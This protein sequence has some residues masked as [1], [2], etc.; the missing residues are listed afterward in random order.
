MAGLRHSTP[1]P[2]PEPVL[3]SRKH[4]WEIKP[5]LMAPADNDRKL[6][7][8]AEGGRST[9]PADGAG[10][11]AGAGASACE[12]QSGDASPSGAGAAGAA[13]SGGAAAAD[14]DM[15]MPPARLTATAELRVP[16]DM[17]ERSLLA[18]SAAA[19][20]AAAAGGAAPASAGG[21]AAVSKA[22]AAASPSLSHGLAFELPLRA[23]AGPP[24]A[25]AWP[26]G[27]GDAPPPAPEGAVV[28]AVSG[29]VCLLPLFKQDWWSGTAN[30]ALG[31]ACGVQLPV[32]ADADAGA[33]DAARGG[34]ESSNGGAGA[35]AAPQVGV[36][37]AAGKNEGAVGTAFGKG[38]SAEDRWAGGAAVDGQAAGRAAGRAAGKAA[39][40]AAGSVPLALPRPPRSAMKAGW[41]EE[42][43]ALRA[44]AAGAGAGAGVGAGAAAAAAAAATA[45][46]AAAAAAA[47]V[48]TVTG[49][50]D[51]NGVSEKEKDQETETGG[52]ERGD[53]AGKGPG[54]RSP[55]SI[56]F[57]F[58][59]RREFETFWC[60]EES[61]AGSVDEF[62]VQRWR[63]NLESQD[64]DGRY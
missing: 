31:G 17:L 49:H 32:H 10:V 34:G 7:E 35:G 59:A 19:G 11:R 2:E 61:V 60:G 37:S 26:Q 14:R 58:V 18:Q 38:G 39:G 24:S 50:V 44:E 25:A 8:A 13:S 33:E 51:E 16:L 53:E 21:A 6:A 62:E 15:D 1:E 41:R 55:R 42:V 47:A 5:L 46:A 29:S 4:S 56:T 12:Q 40:R 23:V 3:R 48:W 36:Q 63:R 54:R 52:G 28:G 57:G 30:G 9:A 45:A 20:D 43:Q 22:G 27:G 64:L